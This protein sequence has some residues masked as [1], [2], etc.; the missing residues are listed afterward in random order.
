MATPKSKF[1]EPT[2]KGG[3]N[4]TWSLVNGLCA[5]SVRHA[6]PIS[7][8]TF[9]YLFSGTVV[10]FIGLCV[11]ATENTTVYVSIDT[12]IIIIFDI[13][14]VAIFACI[15]QPACSGWHGSFAG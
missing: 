11:G 14:W 7:W 2:N 6:H 13:D 8:N 12:I 4:N 10:A 5:N 3:K 9:A 15:A 1:K